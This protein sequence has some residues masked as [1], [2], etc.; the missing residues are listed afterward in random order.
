VLKILEPFSYS[1][2]QGEAVM[3]DDAKGVNFAGSD[4]RCDGEA[5]PQNPVVY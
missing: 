3:H 4:P 2:G 5:I 1:V